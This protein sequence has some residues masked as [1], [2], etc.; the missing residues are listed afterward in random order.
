MEWDIGTV[1]LI[2]VAIITVVGLVRL[3][4]FIE[5]YNAPRA[6]KEWSDAEIEELTKPKLRE[7]LRNSDLTWEPEREEIDLP[8]ERG[9]PKKRERWEHL[10]VPENRTEGKW[11]QLKGA[12]VWIKGTSFNINDLENLTS[13]IEI[14]S[15][16]LDTELER[17]PDN[18]HDKNAIVVRVHASREGEETRTFTLGHIDR[19][20]AKDVAK[21]FRSDMPLGGEII[22]FNTNG[23]RFGIKIQI[24]IPPAKER[25]PY[26]K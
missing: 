7:K 4:A 15:H 18:P 6:F 13:I 9:S 21:E 26:L 17:D 5:R 1:G 25:K 24:L 3:Y 19:E 22:K 14:Q 8:Y 16:R 11:V 23:K 2:C 20:T 10:D 12:R